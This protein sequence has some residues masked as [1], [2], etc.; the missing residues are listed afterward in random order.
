MKIKSSVFI[1]SSSETKDCPSGKF[2]EF[3]FIGR[4]NVGKSS[5]INMLTQNKKLAKISGTPGKTLLINH[6]LINKNWFLVDL[7]GYGYAKTSKKE[8]R[9]IENIIVDYFTN[10]NPITLAFVLIDIRLDPQKIDIE[11]MNWLF[12]NNILF[13]IIFTKTDKLRKIEKEEKP[14]KY[15]NKINSTIKTSPE[16]IVSSSKDKTGRK[17]ILQQIQDFNL[18]VI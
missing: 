8:K 12:K 3:A 4:S 13:K 14:N 18:E 1:K 6:F 17:E 10:R 15:I 7:P 16:Y 11:F 2:S 5:L 9:K